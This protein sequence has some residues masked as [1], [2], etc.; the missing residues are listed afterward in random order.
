MNVPELSKAGYQ[1]PSMTMDSMTF[2]GVR[3]LETKRQ[4]MYDKCMIDIGRSPPL[5]RVTRSSTI[6]DTWGRLKLA[7]AFSGWAASES[8]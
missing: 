5:R 2:F 8:L 4:K 6:C 3:R 1:I 7:F